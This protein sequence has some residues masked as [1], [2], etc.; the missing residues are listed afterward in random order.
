M[1]LGSILECSENGWKCQTWLHFE[2]DRLIVEGRSGA[3]QAAQKPKESSG[4]MDLK[5]LLVYVNSL[6]EEF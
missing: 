6:F 5:N 4:N 2:M 3:F 1:R